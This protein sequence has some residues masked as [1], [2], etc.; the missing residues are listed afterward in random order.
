MIYDES[1]SGDDN[2]TSCK[3]SH[4]LSSFSA[5]AQ[6]YF[7]IVAADMEGDGLSTTGTAVITITDSNDNAPEFEQTSVI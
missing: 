3:P 1:Q 2:I 6:I 4:L 5:M 7:L